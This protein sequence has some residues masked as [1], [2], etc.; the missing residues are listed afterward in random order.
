MHPCAAIPDIEHAA[1]LMLADSAHS[2][3][4]RG[5]ALGLAGLHP[6]RHQ[7]LKAQ[8]LGAA[9]G[10][11]RVFRHLSKALQAWPAR[12]QPAAAGCQ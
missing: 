6:A 7:W 3:M 5:I 1:L 11:Q 9:P 12:L 10:P 8:P 4:A 2:L